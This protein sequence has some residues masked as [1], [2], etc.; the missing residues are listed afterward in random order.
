MRLLNV[1]LNF[2]FYLFL[3]S[4]QEE[5]EN[6]SK[7]QDKIVKFNGGT[8]LQIVKLSELPDSLQPDTFYL[9][10]MPKPQEMNVPTKSGGSWTIKFRRGDSINVPLEPPTINSL[11]VLK[12][13]DGKVV[14]D[15]QKNPYI[16]GEGGSL[17]FVNLSSDQG[18]ALD[19]VNC[20]I[21]DSKGILWVG[22]NGSGVS[23]YDGKSF[24]NFSTEN[25]LAGNFVL[26]IC[27]DRDGA[28]WIGTD[29][30]GV[31]K[32]DGRYIHN[33]TTDDG[34]A[35]N[36]V[37]SIL[38]DSK[39]NLWF[40]THGN[41]I[42]KFDGNKFH[43][44]NKTNGLAGDVVFELMEDYKHNIWIGTGENG[45]NIY[46]GSSFL[47]Y[48][49]K[50]G[51]PNNK[52][53]TFSK[54]KSGNIW[55]GTFGGGLS[56][57]DGKRF[58]N[59]SVKDGLAGKFIYSLFCDSKGI[60]WIGT[61][62]TGLSMYDGKQF[63]TYTIKQGIQDNNIRC[64]TEDSKGGIWLG[65]TTC[66]MLLY[67]GEAF[68]LFNKSNGLSVNSILSVFR[69]KEGN[70]WFGTEAGGVNKYDGKAFTIYKTN[71]G[72]RNNT[73][74]SIAQDDKGKMYFGSYGGGVSCFDGKII[75]NL[76]VNQGLAHNSIWSIYMDRRGKLWFGTNGAGVS[77]Y[78]GNSFINYSIKHG[79]AD[80]F[81]NS[82]V[83]D[84]YGNMWFGTASNGIS[85]FNHQTFIT[86]NTGSGLIDNCVNLVIKDKYGNIWCGT[87]NGI[88]RFS[89]EEVMKI[90]NL[91]NSNQSKTHQSKISFAIKLDSLTKEEGIIS[92]TIW[93]LTK[94]NNG[95]VF[96]GTSKG[97]SVIPSS[98]A[99]KPFKQIKSDIETF[100]TT[101][102]YPLK[103]VNYL[104][105]YCDKN[106]IVWVGTGSVKSA[107]LRFDFSKVNKEK[108]STQTYIQQIKVNDE[109]I[110]WHRIQSKGIA[111][112]KSD[113]SAFL[114]HDFFAFGKKL[115]EDENEILINRFKDVHFKGISRDWSL[116]I[117]LTLPFKNNTISFEFLTIE[118]S[119]PTGVK[120]RY[121]LEGYDDKWSNPSSRS[122]AGFGNLFE[123]NYTFKVSSQL[124][125]GEWS[126]PAIFNFT[127]LPPWY[128][129]WWAYTF[130]L[131]SISSAIYLVIRWRLSALKLI[132]L[133]LEK[134]VSERTVE[135]LE[136]NKLIE[137]QKSE[138]EFQKTKIEEALNN[139]KETQEQLIQI[140][141]QKN[142]ALEKTRIARDMHDE[143]GSGLTQISMLSELIKSKSDKE[144][145]SGELE[146]LSV[147]T[148]ELIQN[149]S[150]II[151]A[152]NQD[153]DNLDNLLGYLR[154]F[155]M[156]FFENSKIECNVL[157]H[158]INKKLEITQSVRRNTLLVIKETF[159]NILKHSEAEKV[160]IEI[161]ANEKLTITITENG[162]GFEP[163]TIKTFGNG[164]KN[165]EKRMDEIGGTFELI[166]K[167][168]EGSVTILNL[169]LNK[170]KT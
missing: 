17:D 132:N 24:F 21:K 54:D 56:C 28:I 99:N 91:L 119:N 148:R 125:S 138:V 104:S 23:K 33:Y 149:M 135:L 43:T 93:G 146:K 118:T 137:K 156:D 130:Y 27:E 113:S 50:D 66:G 110:N 112:N 46:N 107:L 68:T 69:D 92:N 153:N 167:T 141:N 77:C 96:I 94:D 73:I 19:F 147:K 14:L 1:T 49:T 53:T 78:D 131:L 155:S 58:K 128:R 5:R 122:N 34:L 86:I 164:L 45:I 136:K 106:D 20:I 29:G 166:S 133:K 142:L 6:T 60:L 84:D 87:E 8:E 32:Y 41:G 100:N 47:N 134:K 40:G 150:Q 51:L 89:K 63:K 126:K 144:Q 121:L 65:T 163:G 102:G 90:N 4:C 35:G 160:S 75:K 88:N 124:M 12:D 57:F 15:S 42:S 101:E 145:S 85:V 3:F 62:Q 9:K 116:P 64:I 83:E 31:S 139:L 44:F 165:M 48:T 36:I 61:F 127:I 158:E 157:I 79:L 71:Q 123:G 39:G 95:N 170:K 168:G 2:L 76:T 115:N 109:N 72:L 26:S 161:E 52:V 11:D 169:G 114:I 120:Y 162:K 22:T 152:M 70:M 108:K 105:L 55:I 140:E 37:N 151:W 59:Y 38:K 13:A 30:G 98:S 16:L 80:G 154:K 67:K 81:V 117:S 143:I 10:D 82:I 111:K 74:L 18:L 25:G 7:R 97:I 129:T 159:H 103:D